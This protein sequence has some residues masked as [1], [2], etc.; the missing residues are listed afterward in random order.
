MKIVR[1]I[2]INR[3]PKEIFDTWRHLE[4]LPG[5]MTHL[6]SV[7]VLDHKLSHWISKAPAG[8]K[9]AW[10]AEITEEEPDHL[11]AWRSRAGADVPNSGAIRF[12][13][14]PA[15]RGTELTVTLDVAPRG[16][17]LGRTVA[18]FFGDGVKQQIDEGLRRFKCVM[19]TG[20][21]PVSSDASSQ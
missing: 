9:I 18:R 13:Q 2:T 12:V 10:D 4:A 16:G 11:L 5:C 1:T 20:E 3:S 17:V 7:Q 6:V 19:E 14:A 8:R 21:V 15:D